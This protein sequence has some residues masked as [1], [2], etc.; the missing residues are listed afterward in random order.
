MIIVFNEF[1]ASLID[2]SVTYVLQKDAKM[3]LVTE[4]TQ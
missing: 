3:A 1:D 4:E 2:C